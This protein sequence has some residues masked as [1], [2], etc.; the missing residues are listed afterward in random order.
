MPTLSFHSFPD[1]KTDRAKEWIVKIR[2]D[3][4]VNFKINK[5]TKICSQHFKPDDYTFSEYE[6][7]SS[8][9]RLRP[10]AVPSVFPW[11]GHA[12][13]CKSMTSM[14]AVLSQ[15]RCDHDYEPP[16]NDRLG[17][18]TDTMV[19]DSQSNELHVL[20]SKVHAL[21]L[22]ISELEDELHQAESNSEK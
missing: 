15:H 1:L 8:K 17:D 2:R 10:T 21:E 11:T 18:T 5:N 4:G 19:M 7:S 9:P 3:P 12:F 20:E 6:L 14:I 22:R 13:K 16:L